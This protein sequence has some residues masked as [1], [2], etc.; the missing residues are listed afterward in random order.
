M[1]TSGC[2]VCGE[3]SVPALLVAGHSVDEVFGEAGR[4][5]MGDPREVSKP[6]AENLGLEDVR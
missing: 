3:A 5:A 6:E 2:G 4:W 1:P